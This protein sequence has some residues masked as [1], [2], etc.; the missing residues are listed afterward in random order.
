[1]SSDSAGNDVTTAAGCVSPPVMSD[2]EPKSAPAAESDSSANL[3]PG[4][5]AAAADP[6]AAAAAAASAATEATEAMSAEEIEQATALLSRIDALG[7][8]VWK[9]KPFRKFRVALM[10]FVQSIVESSDGRIDSKRRREWYVEKR[11]K[12]AR[13]QRFAAADRH[14]IESRK[15]W[16]TRMNNM[17]T[18]HANI[19]NALPGAEAVPLFPDGVGEN[20]LIG[21]HRLLDAPKV[22]TAKVADV[23]SDAE[24]MSDGEATA[25]TGSAAAGDARPEPA[26]MSNPRFTPQGPQPASVLRDMVTPP[27]P[28]IAG[29]RAEPQVADAEEAGEPDGANPSLN[30]PI[31]CYIC[32]ARFRHLHHFYHALCPSC[33]KLNYEK[34]HQ[35]ADLTDYI[36]L[37]TGSR[38]KIGYQT[39]LKLLRCGAT[40]YATT[41][42][43][44][45]SLSRYAREPDYAKWKDR[46]HVIGI[47][48]RDVVAIEQ[49]CTFL[50]GTLPHLDIIINNAC[51]TI[52]RPAY[53]Y[54]HLM[55]RET[56]L[57]GM[58]DDPAKEA[59]RWSAH[60]NRGPAKSLPAADPA[61]AVVEELE[62]DGSSTGG[63][64]AP[65][66][67]LDLANGDV[68]I[69]SLA[70][71]M[72]AMAG[73]FSEALADAPGDATAA[74]SSVVLSAA[75]STRY[76][77]AHLSQLPLLPEDDE[78]R[79]CVFPAGAL[80]INAQQVDLRKTN[81]WMMKLAEVSTPELIEVFTVNSVA[82]FVL[83][84]RL[85]PLLERSPR[86]ARYIVNVSAMEG[87]FYR[88]KSPNHPHTN[89][90]KAALNMMTRTSSQDYAESSIYM[91]SVDTGWIN[92]EKPL[93]LAARHAEYFQTPIDEVDAMAR[94][95]DPVFDG[96]SRGKLYHGLFMKDYFP[97]EW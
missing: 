17:A 36:A 67:A 56:Q 73:S 92:D 9:G 11:D 8:E 71:N 33:A 55:E 74:A 18:I 82:P 64:P 76:S 59:I 13:R 10:P 16:S 86:A 95:L 37:V 94:I 46:L 49:L 78:R 84:G 85:R 2:T 63:P 52:R 70:G 53:Y 47:D 12:L 87:K 89:M 41:R 43:P 65:G 35:S 3:E 77:S 90:A 68:N 15:L 4:A 75:T 31:G 34:R 44:A 7:E 88:F 79:D 30:R 28:S 26:S 40:V 62:A 19:Q 6:S 48:L 80:D 91:N 61:S 50:N 25:D 60:A 5:P 97:T 39:A 83:N 24:P 27:A 22:D 57:L 96:V 23:A 20:M 81:S 32:R 45:D 66:P 69:M 42:F 58:L 14:S 54:H 1:M 38:V 51:Q 72:M 93:E 29:G 21:D